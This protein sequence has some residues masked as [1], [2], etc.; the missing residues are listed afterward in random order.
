[1]MRVMRTD[2]SPTTGVFAVLVRDDGIGTLGHLGSFDQGVWAKPETLAG[3]DLLSQQPLLTAVVDGWLGWS[4]PV[5]CEAPLPPTPPPDMPFFASC[6]RAWIAPTASGRGSSITPTDAITIQPEAY[7]EYTP[8]SDAKTNR[9]PVFGRYVVRLVEGQ[10]RT[11]RWTSAWAGRW[12]RRWTPTRPHTSTSPAPV[13][14]DATILNL[15]QLRAAVV[16]HQGSRLQPL[17]VIADVTVDPSP[18]EL[19]E[20]LPDGFGSCALLGLIHGGTDLR[21]RGPARGRGVQVSDNSRQLSG[22]NH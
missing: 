15:D 2:A 10:S 4:G 13:P 9:Q 18:R 7:Q 20:R 22:S 14:S 8:E 19:D 12:W 16:G 11:A 21:Q 17:D 6:Q 3:L 5:P 1:M